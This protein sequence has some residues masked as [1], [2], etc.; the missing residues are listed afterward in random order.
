LSERQ[1]EAIRSLT[2]FYPDVDFGRIGL[3]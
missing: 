3:G 2:R 1:R